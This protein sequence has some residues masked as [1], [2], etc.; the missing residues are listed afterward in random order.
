MEWNSL[1]PG[2][3]PGS[4]P[5]RGRQAGIDSV[6]PTEIDRQ[7]ASFSPIDSVSLSSLS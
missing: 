7:T 6:D 2:R 3:S 1:R 4:I 5:E